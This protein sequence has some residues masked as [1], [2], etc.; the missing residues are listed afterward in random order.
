[1]IIGPVN[2]FRT[3]SINSDRILSMLLDLAL[4]GIEMNQSKLIGNEM[5][6]RSMPSFLLTFIQGVLR[7]VMRCYCTSLTFLHQFGRDIRLAEPLPDNNNYSLARIAFIQGVLRIVM[8]RYCTSLTFV[9]QFGRDIR[10]TKPLPDNNN[11]SLA[12]ITIVVVSEISVHCSLFML[13]MSACNSRGELH[14]R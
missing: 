2:I 9:H 10:L 3:H 5:N 13:S 14:Y 6:F 11:Y 8:H 1:M 4:V 7:T 12:R